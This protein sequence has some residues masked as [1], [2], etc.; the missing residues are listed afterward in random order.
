MATLLNIRKVTEG[1]YLVDSLPC[2]SCGETLTTEL[3][4]P[5]LY[6]YNQGAYIQDTFPN[7]TAPDRERF[8]SGMCGKCWD[9][10]F[11]SLDD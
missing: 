6:A 9:E 11:G 10:A 4:G 5:K 7:L 2:P 3:E 8:I 1:L